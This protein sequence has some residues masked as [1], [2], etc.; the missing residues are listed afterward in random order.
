M[1]RDLHQQIYNITLKDIAKPSISAPLI[2]NSAPP[3]V[4]VGSKVPVRWGS[5]LRP[6]LRSYRKESRGIRTLRR[7]GPKL[8]Q[9]QTCIGHSWDGE[10]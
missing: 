5:E 10:F 7:E 6:N 1:I 2:E 3:N 4:R 8:R 9:H